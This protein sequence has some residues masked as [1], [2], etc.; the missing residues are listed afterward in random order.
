MHGVTMKISEYTLRVVFKE[1]N[2]GPQTPCCF[3]VLDGHHDHLLLDWC[4]YP[5][6][7]RDGQ[8]AKVTFAAYVMFWVFH[9]QVIARKRFSWKRLFCHS[10]WTSRNASIVTHVQIST[11]H[12][13]LSLHS[14]KTSANLFSY[15]SQTKDH[16]LLLT[17]K[18]S[19]PIHSECPP[20]YLFHFMKRQCLWFWFS[21]NESVPPPWPAYHTANAVILIFSKT[22]IFPEWTV[23]ASILATA[24]FCL[25][26]GFLRGRVA[27]VVAKPLL[28]S[29]SERHSLLE[30]SFGAPYVQYSKSEIQQFFKRCLSAWQCSYSHV[31]AVRSLLQIQIVTDWHCAL[32]TDGIHIHIPAYIHTLL[33]KNLTGVKQNRLSTNVITYIHSNTLLLRCFGILC[34]LHKNI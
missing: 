32:Q 3:L 24:I 11:V 8:R 16:A 25:G 13:R 9:Q 31:S 26:D 21:T 6:L 22:L 10:F 33:S 23:L 14:L 28:C 20:I 12:S 7:E 30:F 17:R 5:Y 15:S 19:F 4:F 27:S 2:Y 18:S 34:L 29:I 1:C